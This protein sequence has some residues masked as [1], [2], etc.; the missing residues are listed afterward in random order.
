MSA[1]VEQLIFSIALGYVDANYVHAMIS[2]PALKTMSGRLPKTGIG[3]RKIVSRSA[4][5]QIQMYDKP[6]DQEPKSF[7]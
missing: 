5:V 1:L 2:D 3:L 4:A 6:G 7:L